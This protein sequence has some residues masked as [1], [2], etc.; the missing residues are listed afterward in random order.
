MTGLLVKR[1]ISASAVATYGS[2]GG[3]PLLV[4]FDATGTTAP[5]LTGHPFHEL[6]Y[7]WDFDDPGAGTWT[8]GVK[9]TS[10]NY[11]HGPIAG[12]VY[13]TAGTY[14][15]VLTV[16]TADG[17][18][19]E[20]VDLDPIVVVAADTLWS[21]TNTVCINKIG[22]ADFTGKP[23]GAAE[24]NY[25]TVAAALAAITE[26][27][28]RLLFKRGSTWTETASN[29]ISGDTVYLGAYGSGDKP[30]FAQGA[31][32]G[33]PIRFAGNDQRICNI[34]YTVD[35][36]TYTGGSCFGIQSSNIGNLLVYQCD[37]TGT[38]GSGSNA[39]G[40]ITL[41]GPTGI[42]VFGAYEC[43]S[44]WVAN[45]CGIQ[46][47]LVYLGNNLT[48]VNDNSGG[49]SLR[50]QYWENSVAANNRFGKGK[51]NGTTWIVHGYNVG[52]GGSRYLVAVDNY[53]VDSRGGT[54]TITPQVGWTSAAPEDAG[55]IEPIYDCLV[56]SN[57]FSNESAV[58]AN[59]NMFSIQAQ[60]VTARNNILNNY[61]TT[62]GACINLQWL[63]NGI[64]C[65]NIWVYNNTGYIRDGSSTA[66]FFLRLGSTSGNFH[67]WGADCWA[68][69][70]LFRV[71]GGT[72]PSTIENSNASNT[73]ATNSNNSTDGQALNTDPGWVNTSGTMST[74]ED[75]ML[76]G[77]SYAIGAGTTVPVYDDA[78]GVVR[79][80]GTYDLGA[81]QYVP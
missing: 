58:A 59:G 44:T 28:K 35:G 22:D 56:D 79:A 78:A 27:G 29:T 47:K 68:R 45:F 20:T 4:H 31:N 57:Y 53:V 33:I 5:G 81:F 9:N 15:P 19:V 72:S 17:V 36:A 11:A 73:T 54:F 50:W 46:C 23:T 60:N 8:Y 16:R 49:H 70:N 64:T 71:I 42:G 62:G 61:N 55:A 75:F 74:P 24:A 10:K 2:S 12:H 25:D 76:T 43:T 7:E 18:Y 66:E 40:G 21:G 77:S 30:I 39:P 48:D 41:S 14:N 52:T 13:E 65:R 3:A 6:V 69:N 67:Q 32:S 80:G 51:T 38:G 26:A 34:A 37:L 63:R 1:G